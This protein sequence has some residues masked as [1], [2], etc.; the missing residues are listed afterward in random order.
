MFQMLFINRQ[1]ETT[2]YLNK[3]GRLGPGIKNILYFISVQEMSRD[4]TKARPRNQLGVDMTLFIAKVT[5]LGK[6]SIYLQK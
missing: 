4:K 3:W 5:E 1:W 6:L 2:Y